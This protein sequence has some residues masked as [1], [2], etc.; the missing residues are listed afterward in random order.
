MNA[1]VFR[2]QQRQRGQVMILFALA[3][4]VILGMMA[5]A[6]DGSYG[7]VQN[8]RAQNATDFAA[9]AGAQELNGSSLC[10]GSGAAPT[11]ARMA[12]IVQDIV[13]ANSSPVGS[14]WQATFLD[15]TGAKMT[16]T[17]SSFTNAS[18]S[19]YPPPGAC[20]LT[21]Y[22]CQTVNGVSNCIAG[23]PLFTWNSYLAGIIGTP[24]LG[25]FASAAVGS[26][27]TGNPVSIA[28][29]NKVG[30]HAILG[31]G[32]GRFVV[33]GD[34]FL[35][36]NLAS[37][38]WW[39]SY[40]NGYAYDDGIDAK[41]GSSLY[42][43]G[44]ASGKGGT[45]HTVAGTWDFGGA[46]GQKPMWPLDWC[47][48]GG[49]IANQ[50][51][52]VA[53]AAGEPPP[54]PLNRPACS[55]GSVDLAYNKILADISPQM[56]DPLQAAG[57]PPNPFSSSINCP[58]QAQLTDPFGVGVIPGAG[59]TMKPGEYTKPVKIT[60]AMT[61]GDCSA[62]PGEAAYPG[63]YR[64]DQGLWI[65][66]QTN[67]TVSGT[68]VVLGTKLGYPVA[69]NVPGGGSP[70]VRSGVGNGGPC[71]PNPTTGQG[72]AESDYS[73]GSVCA[74]SSGPTLYGA[75]LGGGVYGT[76][77][78][79]S[80]I[81]GGVTGSHVNLTG[82]TT[83]AYGGS[84]SS[85]T[86]GLVLYQDPGNAAN[87]GFDA[88]TADAAVINLTGVV[89]NGSLA[90]Y[91]AGQ[92]MRIWDS[93]GGIP[94]YPGGTLQTGFGAGW[95]PGPAQSTAAGSVTITGTT[96]VDDFNTDG[97]TTITI[98]GKPYKLPGGGI[99]SLLG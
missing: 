45:I 12:N 20:G 21:V 30:P 18:N 19:G 72:G 80:L 29:L 1:P 10:S 15:N 59:G 98:I 14:A 28:S 50:P 16:G 41:V 31:G 49:G 76:G 44:D 32:T 27:S 64:F 81:I 74:G 37:W 69:G 24:Q 48:A 25:G 40:Q 67:V 99:L 47:F 65:T 68:N 26:I 46:T 77:D 95:N 62:I 75:N 73:A 66:P 94:A 35:N 43:F 83:G 78:N 53:Y 85:P 82:P 91:G 4:I 8:R 61:F 86:A 56:S 39:V 97:A 3:M 96:V 58:G 84:G 23:T 36:T 38:P 92:T 63:I 34:I 52:S 60:T 90:N 55:V 9:F 89:Y 88:Q 22:T 13:S 71:F 51:S 11:T 54:Y 2:R 6:L 5:I 42:V 57:A 70:F 7:F 93:S 79:F 17:G 87:F 33:S